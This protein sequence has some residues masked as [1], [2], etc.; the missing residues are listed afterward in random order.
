MFNVV[1]IVNLGLY[2]FLYLYVYK[3]LVMYCFSSIFL[4]GFVGFLGFEW[5]R[6]SWGI[7]LVCF[8]CGIV[9]GFGYFYGVGLGCCGVFEFLGV[10]CGYVYFF[11]RI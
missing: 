8:C 2:C 5:G 3:G 7:V 10:V 4:L 1:L 6:R 11:M 9:L